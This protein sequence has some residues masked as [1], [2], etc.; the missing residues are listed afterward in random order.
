MANAPSILRYVPDPRLRAC[1]LG[2][3]RQEKCDRLQRSSASWIICFSLWGH[4]LRIPPP[5]HPSCLPSTQTM[6]RTPG[7]SK[8][9]QYLYEAV[10]LFCFVF[11]WVTI[12]TLDGLQVHSD[13]SSNTRNP[14]QMKLKSA[15]IPDDWDDDD[16]Q[17]ETDSREIW[18]TAYAT[19]PPNCFLSPSGGN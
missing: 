12:L 9:H 14:I 5:H 10:A 17:E 6:P 18:A 13:G 11:C 2:C 16:E 1:R 19:P 3:R 4:P 8:Q 15:P 7:E